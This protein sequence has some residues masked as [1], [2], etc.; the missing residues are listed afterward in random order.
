[1]LFGTGG[2]QIILSVIVWVTDSV[3]VGLRAFESVYLADHI[4]ETV[5]QGAALL[6]LPLF[7]IEH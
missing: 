3:V 4:P 2:V 6:S 1:M 5:F 7:R